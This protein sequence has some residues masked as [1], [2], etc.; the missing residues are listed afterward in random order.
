MPPSEG[1]LAA[2]RIPGARLVSLPAG[3]LPSDERP[4]EFLS[5]LRVFL[6]GAPVPL[7]E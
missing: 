1:K 4:D 6:N 7:P 2:A 3:H 5:T